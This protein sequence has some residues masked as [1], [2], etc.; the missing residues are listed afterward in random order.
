MDLAECSEGEDFNRLVFEAVNEISV[1]KFQL[2]KRTYHQIQ[3][4]TGLV[5]CNEKGETPLAIAIKG[6]NVS[7]I[8]ELVM[9]LL[10]CDRE[11]V[12][13]HEMSLI[14][15]DKLFHHQIPIM[16]TCPLRLKTSLCPNLFM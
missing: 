4:L 1:Y 6:G 16:A 3:V 13:C 14:V 11:V 15:I 10:A 5:Q 7:L 8:D 2:V 12:K 9:F